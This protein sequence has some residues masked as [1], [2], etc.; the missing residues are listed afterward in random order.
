MQYDIC[1][2]GSALVDQ[3]FQID[4]DFIKKNEKRGIVKGGMTLIEKNDQND[5][6]QELNCLL[7][8]SDAAD[9]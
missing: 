3:T 7:Y 6:I 1:C 8:T 2:L 9:D 4:D 5:L